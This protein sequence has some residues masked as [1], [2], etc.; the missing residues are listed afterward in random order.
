MPALS[1]PF[2]PHP[3]L[4]AP[5]A[6]RERR[7][8]SCEDATMRFVLRSLAVEDDAVKVEDDGGE[9]RHE[10]IITRAIMKRAI[11]WTRHSGSS[12]ESVRRVC[13]FGTSGM[14]SARVVVILCLAVFEPW[15]AAH[16]GAG[17]LRLEDYYR[18][19]SVQSPAMSPDG[20][21]VA[22]IRTE[23]VEAENRRQGELWLAPADN[24][25]APRRVSD[26]AVNAAGPRWSP[27]G[28]LLAFSGRRRGATP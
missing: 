5:L 8:A 28:K 2:G 19:I 14:V 1:V 25:T 12:L 26:P 22:F 23:V 6:G 7:A 17:P 3:D 24:S 9:R 4:I 15:L 21:W 18:L 11:Q 27:D 10:T 20:R 13:M 16:A